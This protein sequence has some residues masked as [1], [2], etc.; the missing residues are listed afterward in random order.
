MQII[1][2]YVLLDNF[3]IDAM[4][5][6]LTNKIIKQ[7][8]NK[9]GLVLAS[10]FGAGFA[11]LSPL[12]AVGG[13]WAICIKLAVAMVMAFMLNF[14]VKKMLVKFVLLVMLTFAFGGALI[15][16]FNFLGISVYDSM[17]IGYVSSLPL[18]AIFVSGIVFCVFAVRLIKS[19]FDKRKYVETTCEIEIGINEKSAKVLGFVDSGNIL[20]TS[21]GKSVIVVNEETLKKW[22]SPFERIEIMRGKQ[23]FLPNCEDL[24][25]SSMGGD[26]KIRVFDCKVSILGVQKDG[27]LG[28]ALG[29]I[30]YGKCEA[31]ISKDLLEV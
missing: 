26:Y 2:E 23:S 15:A 21:Q 10:A 13:V 14:T 6:Y 30:R 4:L 22:F 27:A 29:K 9:L 7:P 8:L 16:V 3:L 5:L 18:G 31:I 17:Y 1:I 25:V 28:V 11:V 12:I 24:L 19:V 20:R